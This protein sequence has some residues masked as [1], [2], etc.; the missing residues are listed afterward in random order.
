[1]SVSN[2]HKDLTT[3]VVWKKL[4]RFAL[5]IFSASLLQSLYG[6]VDL[7]V[8]GHFADSAA[9][10]GVST[11][12]MTMQ[13]LTGVVFGLTTGVTV[14]LGQNIGKKDGPAGA[15]TI[16]AALSLF[17]LV[18]LG[19][20]AV[21]TALAGPLAVVMNAPELAYDDTVT[22]IRICG[23]GII[24]IVLYNAISGIFRGMGDS[25]TPLIL[26]GVACAVNV[27]GDLLFVGL[28]GMGTAGAA[29]ATVIAQG[30]SAVCA[31][32]LLQKKSPDPTQRTLRPKL[33]G[34]E[35]KKILFYGVPI[36]MQELLTGVSFMVILAILNSFGLTAS[37]GVGI[38]ERLAGLFFIIPGSML[39]ALSAFSAQNV[40]AGRRERARAAMFVS[41]IMTC[42]AGLLVFLASFWHGELLA[43]LFS[44]NPDDCAAAGDY[45]RSYSIDCVMVGV[46]FSIMGYLN[47]NGKTGFVALQGILSAFLVRIPF[48]YFMSKIEGVTLFQIG[49]AT[50][51]ATVFAIVLSVSYLAHF[52][53]KMKRME[54]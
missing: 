24:C 17:I 2:E 7:L 45:L 36:A 1:M 14:L 34:H 52:E 5:P 53:R 49:F 9:V 39:A 21:I 12:G 47:G 25:K 41:M 18:A 32:L 30:V 50:P 16:S 26:V 13:T 33:Y 6:T 48:S 15:R 27:V 51:M 46:N 19:L 54:R 22:Y 11:G 28:C 37:A 3:G 23:G 10:S 20:T 8:V 42:S 35:I 40:G 38:A 31:F 44:N 29:I 43:S 4:L